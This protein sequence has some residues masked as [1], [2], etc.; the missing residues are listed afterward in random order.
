MEIRDINNAI[1]ASAGSFISECDHHYRQQV[2]D[3]AERIADRLSQSRVILLSGPSGSSKTT[4][5]ENIAIFLSHYDVRCHMVSMDDYYL[6]RDSGKYP[7]DDEGNL[8]FESPLGLDIAL[9]NQ[10]MDALA[11]GEP[12]QIPHFD[13]LKK[14]RDPLGWRTLQLAPNEVVIFEGINALNPLFTERN[15]NAQRVFIAPTT[16]IT[17]KGKVLF[18]CEKIRL[19][20]RMVRDFNFRGQS[21][22]GTLGMWSSVRRGERLFVMPYAPSADITIDTTLGYEV[23]VLGYLAKPMLEKLPEDVP[24]RKLVDEILGALP[25]IAPIAPE[26]VPESSLLRRE[27]I[28]LF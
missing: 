25:A 13:F 9:M 5:A 27:F 7:L 26:L 1:R 4:T 6:D 16:P 14:A 20:R 8:D 18:D 28:G 15:P 23:P 24:Q 12:T 2:H 19:L 10:N 11:R 21:P 3:A 22:E 17:R